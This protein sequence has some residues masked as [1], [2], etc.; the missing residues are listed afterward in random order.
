MSNTINFNGTKGF[1]L[2]SAGPY[3]SKYE[4]T[5]LTHFKN[6]MLELI[7]EQNVLELH[8]ELHFCEKEKYIR[9]C[10]HI[11][12][13]HDHKDYDKEEDMRK[14]LAAE[15]KERVIVIRK[16]LADAFERE[17]ADFD[18]D[19]IAKKFNY[20]GLI[21]RNISSTDYNDAIAESEKFIAD[22]YDRAL[23]TIVS[24]ITGN[25]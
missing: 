3:Q 17:F 6:E 14:Q 2:T 1:Y 19:F 13:Y 24:V 15:G 20:L 8:Y 21:K 18:C 5:H 25:K 11:R 7:G 23:K 10:C 9:L 12:K 16:N 22:T 4:N